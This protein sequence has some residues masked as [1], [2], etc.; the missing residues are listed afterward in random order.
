MPERT[1]PDITG[2]LDRRAIRLDA[3]AGDRDDAVRQTGQALLDTGA[4]T[5]EYLVTMFERER[6]VS[7]YLGEGFAIPHGTLD[8]KQAVRRDAL[9]FLRFPDGVEWPD[10]ERVRVCIGIAARADGHLAI[11]AQ[12]AEILLDPDRARALRE[13]ADAD[14][15][16]R[17]LSPDT[18]E[19]DPDS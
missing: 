6:S 1:A 4:V 8:G 18:D 2:L 7:T 15:V 17:L 13:V 12:L 3:R 14:E 10:G 19:G 16:L 11:L 9:S 5:A